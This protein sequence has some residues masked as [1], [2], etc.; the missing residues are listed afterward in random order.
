MPFLDRT[1]DRNPA[2]IRAAALLHS[3]GQVP[4]NTFVLDLDA[5]LANARLITDEAER[6]GLSVYFMTKQ[7]GRA[8][9]VTRGVTADGRAKTVAVDIQD[10]QA[11]HENGVPLGHCGNVTQIANSHLDYLIGSARP[12]VVSVFSVEKARAISLAAQRCGL[13]QDVLLRV[14]HDSDLVPAGTAGGITLDELS[15]AVRAIRD[16]PSVQ[17]AGVST[18]PALGYAS[19]AEPVVTPNFTTMLRAAELLRESGV[20]VRQI[21]SPGN[22]CAGVLAVLRDA[23]ATHVEPGSALTGHT[24]FHLSGDRSPERPALVY[25]SEVSHLVDDDVWFFGGG[26]FFDDPP[27]PELADFATRRQVL[28]GPDPDE[29]AERKTRFLGRSGAASG[30]FGGIDYYGTAARGPLDVRV[31]DTVV[32][33]FRTQAFVTRAQVAVVGAASSE[34]PRLVGL[35]DVRGHRL[36]PASWW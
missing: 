26:L 7:I 2:L 10:A 23:G 33:A 35:Y 17:I 6:L 20:D 18:W 27:V 30:T 34:R 3:S 22:T 32:M 4:P 21:N 13:I 25:V 14:R 1:I 36:D 12:D 28:I 5:M 31:G 8:P 15:A 24:T 29:I 16:L 9:D 11:L 19:A